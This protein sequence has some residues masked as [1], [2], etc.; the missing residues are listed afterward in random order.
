MEGIAFAN[1]AMTGMPSQVMGDGDNCVTAASLHVCDG[2]AG[3]QD[4]PV[5]SRHFFN[6]TH[7]GLL[8]NEEV[9]DLFFGIVE[10][11]QE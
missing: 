4:A 9:V 6:Q 1:D 10:G 5:V 11:L 7:A 8:Y 2:W 3:A